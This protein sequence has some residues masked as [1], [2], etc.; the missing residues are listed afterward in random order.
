[1]K[2]LVWRVVVAL[3][4][5]CL[6]M[7]AS[8]VTVVTQG[9]WSGLGVTITSPDKVTVG[10]AFELS[11]LID[12]G[13]LGAGDPMA[14]LS[15]V[16]LDNT[17]GLGAATWSYR[18]TSDFLATPLMRS[19]ALGDANAL[20]WPA[21]AG[22]TVI[23]LIDPVA[24]DP[25][26]NPDGFTFLSGVSR[27]SVRWTLSDLMMG[28]DIDFGLTLDDGGITGAQPFNAS[29]AVLAQPAPVPEPAHWAQLLGGLCLLA[30]RRQ[31][32]QCQRLQA[33]PGNRPQQS[34]DV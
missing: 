25:T 1:M 5:L 31:R 8:A 3:V 28:A 26:F 16:S 33:Q 11:F 2:S 24:A 21:G 27:A 7:Q 17:L 23:Q 9:S 34:P 10:T 20:Q 12:A 30:W 14:F 22:R 6:P 15:N 4:P 13:S 29:V 32:G 18:F 19:G